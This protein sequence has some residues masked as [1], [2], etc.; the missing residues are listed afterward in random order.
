MLALVR[1]CCADRTLISSC[2]R[3]VPTVSHECSEATDFNKQSTV[4]RL[5]RRRFC[6]TRSWRAF[7]KASHSSHCASDCLREGPVLTRRILPHRQIHP[8]S[9][10]IQAQHAEAKE[11]RARLYVAMRRGTKNPERT[12][13]RE[14]H[15]FGLKNQK[16]WVGEAKATTKQT[17]L[18]GGK[19]T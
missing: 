4:G 3:R 9:R 13:Q 8:L 16:R 11:G 10:M 7:S 17:K 18:I 14:S 6:G 15:S 19:E 5:S 1:R 12:L 2:S